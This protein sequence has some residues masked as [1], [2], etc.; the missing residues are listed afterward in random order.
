M[1]QDG[2]GLTEFNPNPRFRVWPDGTTQPIE[3]TPYAWKSD[4]YRVVS[5]PTEED[6]AKAVQ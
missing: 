5:A 4:D 2:R 3:E 1:T 6:A